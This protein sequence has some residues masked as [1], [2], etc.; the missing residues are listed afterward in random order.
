[1]LYFQNIFQN[2]EDPL[3]SGVVPPKKMQKKNWQLPIFALDYRR[4]MSA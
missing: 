4:R 3:A 1:M 2:L